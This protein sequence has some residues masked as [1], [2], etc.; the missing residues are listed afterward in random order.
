MTIEKGDI[1]HM[2]TNQ[3]FIEFFQ[4]KEIELIV[5][6]YILVVL[7]IG[8]SMQPFTDLIEGL[9]AIFIAPGTLITD[10][11][12]IGGVGPALVNAGIVGLIGYIIL[13]LNKVSFR[14]MAIAVLFTMVGF[15]LMGKNVWSVLPIIFGVFIYSKATGRE[16]V[17]N[18]YPALFGT[19]L[20]PLVTQAAF[21]WGWGITGGIIMGILVGI[22]ISPVASH[23]LSFHEGHNLYNVG[24]TAGFVGFVFL[25]ILR[26]YGF[27]TETSVSWA[28][29]YDS[30]LRIFSIGIFASMV[31][32]GIIIAGKKVKDY[33]KILKYPGTLITD[34]VN[35]GGFGNTLINMGLVGL[36]GVVYIEL[37]GTN[38][39]GPT[40]SGLF[41]MVG[42]AAFGK[43]PFNI[44]PIMAGVWIGSLFSIYEVSAPGTVLA[45]LFGTTLAPVAGQ[46]GPIIGILAGM[47]HLYVVSI[48]GA[49]HGGMNLYNNGFAAGFVAA[50]FVAIMKGIKKD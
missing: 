27:D 49:M 37:V 39:N 28:T 1:G 18:I 6:L 30:L 32:I 15:A 46:F 19:A 43:H 8:L 44:I 50:F 45:A 40:I 9:K 3:N 35:I 42:F 17:T 33:Y 11:M 22:V 5:L 23:V 16:F 24:F 36:I 7:L 12:V 4:K 26:G 47:T 48:T 25:S 29:E 34:F 21:A 14:G 2:N 41:T 13:V 10:Y 31:I 20:A 38:Y